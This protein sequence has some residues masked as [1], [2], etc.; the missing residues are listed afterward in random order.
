MNSIRKLG[1]M[2][3]SKSATPSNCGQHENSSNGPRY[4]RCSLAAQTGSSLLLA[5]G[6]VKHRFGTWIHS[7]WFAL[8]PLMSLHHSNPQFFTDHPVVRVVCWTDRWFDFSCNFVH[9]TCSFCSLSQM[10]PPWPHGNGICIRRRCTCERF[11]TC[12]IRALL[13]FGGTASYI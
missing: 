8:F 9:F 4:I 6:V 5:R 13:H 12:L 10:T 2:S 1:L 11:R 7:F 3:N